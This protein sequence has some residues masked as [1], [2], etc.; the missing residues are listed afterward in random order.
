VLFITLLFLSIGQINAQSE[1]QLDGETFKNNGVKIGEIKEVK[2]GFLQG[3]AI[4]LLNEQ[5]E[6]LLEFQT[7]TYVIKTPQIDLYDYVNVFVNA[8]N[9]SIQF[10]MDTFKIL[11]GCKGY[12][13]LKKKDWA[14]FVNNFNLLNTDGSLNYD[15][16]KKVKERYPKLILKEFLDKQN[17]RKACIKQLLTPTNR[18]NTIKAIVTE[19]SRT[20][21]GDMTVINYKVEHD[22]VILGYVIGKGYSTFAANERAEIDYKVKFLPKITDIPFSYEIYN[23]QVNCMAARYDGATKKLY[24]VCKDKLDFYSL[25]KDILKD[26]TESIQTRTALVGAMIDCLILWGLY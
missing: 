23:T 21:E 10:E 20:I 2:L 19:T 8:K 26:N 9:D 3:K 6:T 5:N 14:A 15:S 16:L 13:S 17:E 24:P 22:S 1:V 11:V 18:K 7:K 12:K 25:K 4:R